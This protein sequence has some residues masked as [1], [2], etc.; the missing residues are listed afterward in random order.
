MTKWELSR[1]DLLKKLGIGGACLPLLNVSRSYAQE[2]DFPKR[3]IVHLQ[4]EGYRMPNWLPAAGPLTGPLPDS[5]SPLEA[6]KNKLIFL[7]NLGNEHFPGC[8]RWAHGAYGQIFTAGPT[9]PNSGNGKEYWEPTIPSVDQV[10][11]NGIAKIAPQLS[12]KSL[13]F[14]IGVGSGS[15]LGSKRCFW[16]GAKQ[17]ITPEPDPYKAYADIFGGRPANPTTP[18][19]AIDRLVAE[20]K[21]ILDFVGK[22]LERFRDR[23]GAEDKMSVTGHLES[24]RALEK[25][26]AA[27]RQMIGACGGVMWSGDPAR[28]IAINTAN[29]PVL[30]TLQMQLIVA[31]LK[32]DVTR[33]GTTQVGDA[34]GGRIIFDFVPGVPR[35]GNGYQPNRDWHDLGH[36]PVRAG[37]ADGDDKSKVDKWTM[38]KFAELLTMLKSVPEGTGNMLDSTTVLW[39]N[40]MED[41]ANHGAVKIPWI[42][43]GDAKGYLKTGQCLPSTGRDIGGVL[44]ELCAAMDVP[45]PFFGN[46]ATG[47]PMPELRAQG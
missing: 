40:H 18:D 45:V 26:L 32:C 31:A 6:F 29:T 7:A 5:T 43:A 10:V 25:Q 34:T 19:P 1:R 39:G 44:A 23:L 42:I 46:E 12:R 16:S 20:R 36:R 15:F 8:D 2:P 30:W 22:D 3:F 38:T 11:A 14:E 37:V 27:P 17:P 13:A 9:D 24:I 28:P 4:T 47:K 33:V 21:S 35:Q 41:G